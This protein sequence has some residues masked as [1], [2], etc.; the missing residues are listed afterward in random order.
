[1]KDP[2]AL[3]KA[4]Y[5]KQIRRQENRFDKLGNKIEMLLTFEEWYKIWIDSGHYEQRGIHKGCY[6]MSRKNDI[7]H[8]EI[9]NV[10]IKTCEENSS[11]KT[12]IH[13][14]LTRARIS[15]GKKGSTAG[16][17]QMWA[18]RRAKYGTLGRSQEATRNQYS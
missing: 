18:T 1:M 6:C 11:E 10:D 17:A 9:G 8:Y 5:R 16:K 13:S 4:Q 15:A 14:V 2:L 7:G 12:F 3:A